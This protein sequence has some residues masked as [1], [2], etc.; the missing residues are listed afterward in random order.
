MPDTIPPNILAVMDITGDHWSSR[1]WANRAH[2]AAIEGGQE[3]ICDLQQYWMGAYPEPPVQDN[4]GR[5]VQA[6]AMFY[7][8]TEGVTQVYDGT[9]WHNVTQPVPGIVDEYLFM[10]GSPTQIFTGGD[11]YGNPVTIDPVNSEVGVFL[12]G[13][14]LLKT[15]DY[16]VQ[17]NQ[18]TMVTG[19]VEPPNVV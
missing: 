13:V 12:N 17:P 6:G 5:P 7:N 4:C 10:P 2:E 9:G 15:I 1:W 18:I 14:R 16:T 11:Y 8:T 19:A 3:A